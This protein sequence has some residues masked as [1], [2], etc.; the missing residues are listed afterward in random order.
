M[1]TLVMVGAAV[2]SVTAA[3]GQGTGAATRGSVEAFSAEAAHGVGTDNWTAADEARTLVGWCDMALK[4]KSV[5]NRAR[6]IRV[7]AGRVD[8]ATR[9]QRRRI[10]KTA[11]LVAENRNEDEGIRLKAIG[12]LYVA[13]DKSHV[14]ALAAIM[15]DATESA[16]VDAL[17][18]NV[19][20]EALLAMHSCSKSSSVAPLRSFL[21]ADHSDDDPRVVFVLTYSAIRA[22]GETGSAAAQQALQSARETLPAEYHQEINKLLA[23]IEDRNAGFSD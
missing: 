22:L 8:D 10:A 15:C 21:E 5:A 4:A 1:R 3:L 7:L 18:H 17:S 16:N 9:S 13:G 20:N 23:E 14:A 2:F 19:R 11:M 6:A 12:V